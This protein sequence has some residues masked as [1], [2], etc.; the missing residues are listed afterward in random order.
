MATHRTSLSD[1]L[2]GKEEGQVCTRKTA[3][4]RAETKSARVREANTLAS[5]AAQLSLL[6]WKVGG[7]FSLENPAG[8]YIWLYGPV[9]RL[10]QLEGVR[11]FVGD[12]C[13]FMG[14]YVK[15]T[16]WLSN[17]N[18]MQ[19]LQRRCS[20]RPNRQHEPLMGLTRDFYG[21][22]VFKTSLAAGYPQGQDSTFLPLGQ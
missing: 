4:D 16:G 12:Q 9:K 10:L 19:V 13:M 17:A 14:E 22:K 18:F 1:I 2:K 11:L 7:W 6:Q 8:S 5:R 20:G 15:P 21:N 3:E